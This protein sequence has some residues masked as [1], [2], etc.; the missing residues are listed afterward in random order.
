MLLG[1][2]QSRGLR[3]EVVA[4]RCPPL[5]PHS[6][7]LFFS[8]HTTWQHPK[9]TQDCSPSPMVQGGEGKGVV[10]HCLHDQR[11][12]P[13]LVE[14]QGQ[15]V[16]HPHVYILA[17]PHLPGFARV[18]PKKTN[19]FAATGHRRSPCVKEGKIRLWITFLMHVELGGSTHCAHGAH[20]PTQY[21][22]ARYGDW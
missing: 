14:G 17:H 12:W 3:S 11:A 20:S 21:H 19:R 2:G 8:A 13:N 4:P 15:S 16:C 6:R 18:L 5:S 22:H 10:Q 1:Q 9:Y 7:F